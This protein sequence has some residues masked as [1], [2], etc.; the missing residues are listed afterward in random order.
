MSFLFASH[1]TTMLQLQMLRSVELGRN[2][3][4]K[5]EYTGTLNETVMAHLTTLSQHSLGDTKENHDDPRL[6]QREGRPCAQRNWLN[7]NW[8]L[9]LCPQWTRD[10]VRFRKELTEV[11]EVRV[12]GSK[13]CF[14]GYEH[15]RLIVF[16]NGGVNLQHC[17]PQRLK[18]KHFPKL[19]TNFRANA[20]RTR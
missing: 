11:A 14:N 5:D 18:N 19:D 17:R 3:I 15:A 4:T 13:A 6:R 1:L 12:L 9:F 16:E 7:F 20:H 8:G 10:C 2:V